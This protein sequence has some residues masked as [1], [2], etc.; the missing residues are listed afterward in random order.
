MHRVS[1][2]AL[3]GS[4]FAHFFGRSR[5]INSQ[6][7]FLFGRGVIGIVRDRN[8]IVICNDA[9]HGYMTVY[10]MSLLSLQR[11]TSN[12]KSKASINISRLVKNGEMM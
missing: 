5:E 2:F 3:A 8:L 10:A 6:S 12:G 7:L 9:S 4:L 1:R 11:L